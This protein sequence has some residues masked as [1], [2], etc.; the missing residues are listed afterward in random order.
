MH[1]VRIDQVEE[2]KEAAAHDP[3]A[4]RLDVMLNGGVSYVTLPVRQ[5]VAD[6]HQRLGE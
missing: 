1:N 2:T 3:S 5:A 6:V 4:A